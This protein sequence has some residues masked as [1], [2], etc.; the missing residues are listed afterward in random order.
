MIIGDK[1]VG[2]LVSGVSVCRIVFCV[3]LML[4]VGVVLFDRFE[5]I[6][7]FVLVVVRIRFVCLCVFLCSVRIGQVLLFEGRLSLIFSCCFI[8]M[9]KCVVGSVCIGWLFIVISCVGILL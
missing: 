2:W 4:K 1:L 6:G 5:M 8:V 3:R 9:L 7:I